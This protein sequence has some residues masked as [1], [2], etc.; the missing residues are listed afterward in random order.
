MSFSEKTK[1]ELCRAPL[2][3]SCCQLAEVYGV[4][5]YAAVFTHREIRITTES[6]AFARRAALLLEK[7]FGVAVAPVVSGRRRVLRITDERSLRTIMTRLGYD[8]KSH[9]TYHLNRNMIE[10]ECCAASFLR[11]IFL[12]SG[13]DVYKRQAVGDLQNR[14]KQR[15]PVGHLLRVV[16]ALDIPWACSRWNRPV[17]QTSSPA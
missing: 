14:L 15:M 9:I 16:L 11:G 5:L 12:M 6:Q 4:L 2:G 3:R 10:G 7:V 13:S 1:T 8:F 17:L